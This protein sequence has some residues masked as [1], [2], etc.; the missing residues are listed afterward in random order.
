[1]PPRLRVAV[2][3]LTQILLVAVSYLFGFVL[4]LDLT[5]F[6][7]NFDE[8]PMGLIGKTLPILVL[9]RMTSLVGFR[10]HQRV[11]SY[12]GVAD[13]LQ[14]IKATTLSSLAFVFLMVVTFGFDEFPRSVIALDWAGNIVL[15]SGVSMVVRIIK[16]GLQDVGEK[17]KSASRLLIIGA[18]DAGA[19]LCSEA[20]SRRHFRFRPV[21]FVDDDA[22]K[23]GTSILG[24]PVVGQSKDIA[25]ATKR[26][27][28]DMAVIAVPA[29]TASQMRHLV[30]SCTQANLPFKV[31]P[32]TV[33]ILDGTVSF[34]RI[35]EIDPVDLLGRPPSKLDRQL[36]REF[37]QNKR[38]L[39]TG[40]GGSVGSELA[41][42]LASLE[43]A[44]LILMDHSE[45]PQFFLEAE[46]SNAFP[47]AP[48]VFPVDDVT[49]SIALHALMD[50]Y[51]PELVFHA[52]AHKHV[53][54]MERSPS[55]AVKNNVGSTYCVAKC[56]IDAGVENFVLVSTDKAANPTSVMG[57]TKRLSE[58]LVQEMNRIG[59]TR[60]VSVRFG[61][62]IGS[63]AS[64]VPI[65][66]QQIASGGPITVTHPEARRYFMSVSEATGLIMQAAATGQGRE[67]FVLDMG[68]PISIVS[69]AETLIELSGLKPHED[70]E[71]VYTG[72]RPG[73]KLL[74]ELHTAADNFHP[75]GIEK[76]FVLTEND[77][78]VPTLK[79]I[80][81][82][83]QQIPHLQPE[84]VKAQLQA[85]VPE[86]QPWNGPSDTLIRSD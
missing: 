85:L 31:L 86:Y 52:A 14:I 80:E 32:A 84:Q 15:L 2:I 6:D 62:V 16:E 33:D 8:L 56:A 55:Q 4:R 29:A 40:A 11:W 51:K 70:I 81:G 19:T 46:L 12:F 48:M 53:P 1:M 49:D 76:L 67:T 83:L 35:R 24:V 60:F 7:R 34:T 44:L 79:E 5:L 27:N 17:G 20:L 45:N 36:I 64:V 3:L 82:F 41:R 13:L 43:P 72:L 37:I 75:T 28:V 47:Q 23:T 25:D 42:H 59:K 39:V 10:L 66:K 77:D 26:Y 71:I 21:A 30:D 68:E 63:N 38:V 74:E 65:F 18:G 50:K 73:E 78:M 57:V 54:L 58:I 69:L 22:R 9:F 61:N